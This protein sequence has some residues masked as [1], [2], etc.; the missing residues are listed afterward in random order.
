MASTEAHQAFDPR[1][2]FKA[3][4]F[5]TC[6]PP[7]GVVG[8]PRCKL[9]DVDEAGLSL[10]KLNSKKGR[11]CMG[12]RVRKRG[13]YTRDK[14]VCVRIAISPGDPALP[15]H[16]YGSVANPRRWVEVS[17]DTGTTATDFS[18]LC[19]AIMDDIDQNEPGNDERYFL[20]DNLRLH[21]A[22]LVYQTVHGRA[23]I[24]LYH[25]LPRPPYQ[26]KWGPIEY[27]ICQLAERLGARIH[28][29]NNLQHLQEA[30][31]TIVPQLTSFD[32]TFVHCGYS[33]AGKYLH[34]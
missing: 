7:L 34:K 2:V 24:R 20:W 18:K 10:E 15:A 6:P 1:N 23:G 29:I 22:P 13:H 32:A 3:Q 9:I 5:W 26:P 28:S 14:K 12:L 21:L 11:G 27:I 4:V 17:L 30:I 31:M 33:T 19:Q 8:I 16:A 25:I